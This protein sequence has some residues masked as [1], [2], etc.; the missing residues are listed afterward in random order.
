MPICSK[1]GIF[2]YIWAIFRGKCWF[3]KNIHGAYG[4]NGD[5][6]NWWIIVWKS[7]ENGWFGATGIRII[8]YPW[9]FF[10]ALF[11]SVSVNSWLRPIGFPWVSIRLSMSNAS[12]ADSYIESWKDKREGERKMRERERE[13][14]RAENKRP[15]GRAER[16]GFTLIW[17]QNCWWWATQPLL[18]RDHIIW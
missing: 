13:R 5:T 8:D 9:N 11:W 18:A 14:Y 16:G 7:C 3:K 6:P 1:Y 12:G 4:I 10:W 17:L 2:T 15:V